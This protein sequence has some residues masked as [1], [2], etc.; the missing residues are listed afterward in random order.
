MATHEAR[1][2]VVADAIERGIVAEQVF[3]AWAGLSWALHKPARP[4]PGYQF[5][6]G[7][8]RVKVAGSFDRHMNVKT[9]TARSKRD[10][11]LYV[12]VRLVPSDPFRVRYVTGDVVAWCDPGAVLASGATCPPRKR[13]HYHVP[14]SAMNANLVN[15]RGRLGLGGAVEVSQSS[16]W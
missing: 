7:G 15:L 13:C 4:E 2:G 3:C 11:D 14:A 5:V 16:L 6:I 9:G 12:F 1:D 10:A 8:Y